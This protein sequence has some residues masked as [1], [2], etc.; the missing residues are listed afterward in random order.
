MERQAEHC[1]HPETDSEDGA[2]EPI[3]GASQSSAAAHRDC[4]QAAK[5]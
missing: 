1:S 4:I 2:E 3:E 5:D